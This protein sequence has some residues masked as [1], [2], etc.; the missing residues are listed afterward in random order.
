MNSANWM[1]IDLKRMDPAEES[2]FFLHL[3]H[4]IR[5]FWMKFIYCYCSMFIKFRRLRGI[6]AYFLQLVHQRML[7]FPPG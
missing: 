6:R 4:D 2:L 1:Q 5:L 3:Q 7:C